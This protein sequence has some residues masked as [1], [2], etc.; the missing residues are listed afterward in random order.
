MIEERI[1]LQNE[2]IPL[3]KQHSRLMLLW[4]T[5]VGKTKAAL[6]IITY[7]GGKWLIVIAERNHIKTWNDEI[8]KFYSGLVD[9]DIICYQS[10]HKVKGKYTGIILDEGHH[11][12]SDLRLKLIENI[13]SN[14][15]IILTATL[16]DVQLTKFQEIYGEF[17]IHRV[18]LGDAFNRKLLP[19]PYLAVIPIPLDTINLT[20]KIGETA[21]TPQ[22][23]YKHL[24]LLVEF[25]K[26]KFMDAVYTK[27]KYQ[28]FLKNRWL[29]QALDRK[30]W[31]ASQKTQ[32]T[33]KLLKALKNKQ[34][35]CFLGSINQTME[36]GIPAIHSKNPPKINKG[37]S[38]MQPSK[39]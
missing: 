36:I 33:L 35:I 22:E 32:A 4:P 21:V 15:L 5:G 34:I 27:S 19:E 23:F 8:N 3:T 9:A 24:D 38:S 20:E 2:I 39:K 30:H 13:K 25:K 7:H 16:T 11:A 37:R 28:I 26:N 6:D 31:I 18:S 14:N 17:T 29:R 12:L 1:K 10:L